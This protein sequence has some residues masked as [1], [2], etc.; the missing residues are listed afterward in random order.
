MIIFFRKILNSFLIPHFLYKIIINDK[1]YES[2]LDS[3]T[4]SKSI[5]SSIK[6]RI[7]KFVYFW[8]T[9]IDSGIW[10]EG[11]F[12]KPKDPS[13]FI[14][15]RPGID[16]LLLNK[17]QDYATTTDSAI[18]DLG[19]NCGRH[20]EF[21]YNH[22]FRNL[23]G[24]DIMKDAITFFKDRSPDA[25]KGSN[26]CHD[27]FQRFLLKKKTLEYEIVY[28]V[29]ATIEL[30]HPS[31]D[32]IKEMCRVSK[33]YVII[34]IQENSHAYPRFYVTEFKRNNFELIDSQR[35]IADSNVSLLV[36]KRKNH[37]LLN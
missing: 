19:C 32:V 10:A 18:L 13:H 17:V 14:D 4:P 6:R 1:D 2:I 7:L 28:T 30:V 35:P 11:S 9:I 8:P 20:I 12:E 15:L 24:V 37:S 25:Y 31:F 16:I 34:L 21:L 3:G 22:G 27:F 33:S 5:I 29:G 23:S 26:I 36:F